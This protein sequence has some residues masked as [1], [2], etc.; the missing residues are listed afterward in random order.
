MGEVDGVADPDEDVHVPDQQVG[1]AKPLGDR[2]GVLDERVP[3]HPLDALEDD[4]GLAAL[5]DGDGVDR[6]DV[7]VLQRAGHPGLLQQPTPGLPAGDLRADRLDRHL[8]AHHGLPGEVHDAHAADPQHPLHRDR[9]R[10][11]LL[12]RLLP[13]H[14][15]GLVQ[16]GVRLCAGGTDGL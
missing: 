15:D 11:L 16:R 9:A 4:V 14:L 7:G 3:A 6:D 5:V 12:P 2:V 1:G 8:S 10:A 13:E